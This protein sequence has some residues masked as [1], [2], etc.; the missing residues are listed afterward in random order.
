MQTLDQI[1]FTIGSTSELDPLSLCMYMHRSTLV[2]TP[3][4]L[5][6]DSWA[7]P[8]ILRRA[9]LPLGDPAIIL[10]TFGAQDTRDDY[11]FGGLS[12]TLQKCD[13]RV[14]T[15]GWLHHAEMHPYDDA[16]HPYDDA[17]HPSQRPVRKLYFLKCT[18]THSLTHTHFDTEIFFQWPIC[19]CCNSAEPVNIEYLMNR[20]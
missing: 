14:Q 11:R 7:T 17:A 12:P 20:Y 8:R 2:C 3:G 13:L 19:S 4:R 18:H 15:G 16:A 9:V 1:N 10:D 6:G 5:L